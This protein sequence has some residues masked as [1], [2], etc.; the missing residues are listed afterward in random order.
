MGQGEEEFGFGRSRRLFEI[1]KGAHGQD[2]EQDGETMRIESWRGRLFALA[3]S[4]VS[5]DGRK[6]KL[7]E[8][9][10]LQGLV[11]GVVIVVNVCDALGLGVGG[12]IGEVVGKTSMTG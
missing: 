5:V 7:F 2:G 10:A 4:L 8:D 9:I 3:A 11:K 12:E 1:E 6:V